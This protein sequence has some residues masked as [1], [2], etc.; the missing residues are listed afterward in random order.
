M[1]ARGYKVTSIRY[2]SF[3]ECLRTCSL[4]L[5][6]QFIRETLPN[7][8][9]SYPSMGSQSTMCPWF[10]YSKLTRY[11]VEWKKGDALDPTTYSHIMPGVSGVV[12]TLGTLLE[13]SGYKTALKEGDLGALFRSYFTSSG[14][15][16]A[17]DNENSKGSYKVINR[18]TGEPFVLSISTIHLFTSSSLQLYASAIRSFRLRRFQKRKC[19]A[20]VRSCTSQRRTFFVRG[21]QQ[22]TSTQNAKRSSGSRNGCAANRAIERSS[23][24]QV[25]P[26]LYS[27]K[28]ELR[29]ANITMIAFQA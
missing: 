25:R 6:L 9:G 18:D 28:C 15:P 27:A 29:I 1:L 26:P 7:C 10:I 17:K 14:N 16:L 12:H 22:V 2:P 13:S 3:L 20:R 8:K 19:A 21:S 23:Y 4:T 5:T 11:Q 24:D